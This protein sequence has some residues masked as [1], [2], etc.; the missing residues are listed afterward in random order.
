V[1]QVEG[2]ENSPCTELEGLQTSRR[3]FIHAR[4][5]VDVFPLDSDFDGFVVE[6]NTLNNVTSSHRCLRVKPELEREEVVRRFFREV[7]DEST[8]LL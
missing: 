6:S 2:E 7:R 5:E 4:R 8:R 3:P 1:T